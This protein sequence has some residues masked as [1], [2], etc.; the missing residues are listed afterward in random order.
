VNAPGD[1]E[2]LRRLAGT[3][4]EIYLGADYART[5]EL[6]LIVTPRSMTDLGDRVARCRALRHRGIAPTARQFDHDGTHVLVFEGAAGASLV[7]LQDHLDEPLSLAA[8][9]HIGA[10]LAGALDAMHRP[11]EGGAVV[12]QQFVPAHA[13]VSYRGSV[14]LIGLPFLCGPHTPRATTEMFTAPEVVSGVPI[15]ARAN[16]YS[17]AAIVWW[18][19]TQGSPQK[20][21]PDGVPEPIKKALEAALTPEPRTRTIRAAELASVFG[22]AAAGGKDELRAAVEAIGDRRLRASIA[23]PMPGVVREGLHIGKAAAAQ[24]DFALGDDDSLPILFR[25]ED[26]DAPTRVHKPRERRISDR[27]VHWLATGVLTVAYLGLLVMFVGSGN[28][29]PTKAANMPLP[30]VVVDYGY[31][32][33]HSA[34]TDARVFVAGRDVGKVN[35]RLRLA[36]ETHVV[37]VGNASGTRWYDGPRTV[38]VRCGELTTLRADHQRP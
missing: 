16:V 23:P 3:G 31:L 11:S 6:A 15:T 14:Q 21:L 30:R 1:Y 36:C 28:S 5:Q 10:E 7:E 25:E 8:V 27:A 13:I 20:N 37:R 26:G 22:A 2:P 12:H 19:L 24:R 32:E 33:V 9:W 17:L 4:F 38:Q 34:V 18:L 35:D 29:A